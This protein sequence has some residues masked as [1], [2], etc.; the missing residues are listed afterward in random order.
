[1]AARILLYYNIMA[2]AEAF[3]AQLE[4]ISETEAVVE[5]LEQQSLTG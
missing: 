5:N 3:M 2:N 4:K 1:M